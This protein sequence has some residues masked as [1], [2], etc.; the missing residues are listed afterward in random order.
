MLHIL[1]EEKAPRQWI[2]EVPGEEGMHTGTPL[3]ILHFH[4]VHSL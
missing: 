2:A 4:I 3:L 1:G